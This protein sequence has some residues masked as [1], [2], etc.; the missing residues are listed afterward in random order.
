MC[1]LLSPA[2][3]YITGITMVIDG[4]ESLYGSSLEIPGKKWVKNNAPHVFEVG[5]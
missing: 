5:Q 3:S 2:A 4:G 1:F